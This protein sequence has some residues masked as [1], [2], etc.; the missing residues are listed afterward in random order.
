MKLQPL[1]SVPTRAKSL[2]F[3]HDSERCFGFSFYPAK[4]RVDPGC[5]RVVF[6]LR[7]PEPLEHPPP[8]GRQGDSCEASRA[9]PVIFRR[10]NSRSRILSRRHFQNDMHLPPLAALSCWIP[11]SLYL[12]HRYPA[13]IAIL[14]NFLGGWAILPNANYTPTTEIFPYWIL[15]V[16]L[17]TSYLVTKATVTGLSAFAGILLFHSTDLKRFRPGM[18]DLPMAVWCCVPLLSATVHWNTLHEDVLGAIYLAISWGMPWLLGRIY[19]AEFDSLLLAAKACV[20]AATCYVPI[21]LVEIVFGPQ[22]YAF[23]Y[24]YQPYRWVG[25]ARYLGF[26]PIGMMEDGNQLGIWMAAAALI[27]IAFWARSL[28]GSIFG[29]PTQWIAVGLAG[30]TLSCQSAG[31]ILLLILLSPT[32]LLKRHNILRRGVAVLV[33]GIVLF[34]LFRMSG[35]LPLRALAKQNGP[36]HSIATGLARIGRQS[37]FWRFARD[38]SHL[39]VALQQPLL[40]SGRWDWWQNGNARPWGLWMLV[41]GMYGLVGLT[42]LGLILFLPIQRALRLPAKWV[43]PDDPNL[44]L[45]MAGLILMVAIDSLLNGALILPYLLVMGGLAA[46]RARPEHTPLRPAF[47]RARERET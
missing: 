19:F 40:G 12:F 2:N 16:C 15:G 47:R 9:C 37:L 25:A 4:I 21:C 18:C 11:V 20:I 13:R 39:R 24:G 45:A 22:L 6:G 42:A 34:T 30:I 1:L 27:A 5:I 14:A 23:V 17:P 38:E 26:R 33:L 35:L 31:S 29:L 43:G 44:R 41:F 46:R 36:L 7:D 28:A 8:L 32:T 3:L 10:S